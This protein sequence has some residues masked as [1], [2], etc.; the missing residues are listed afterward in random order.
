MKILPSKHHN[1]QFTLNILRVLLFSLLFIFFYFLFILFMRV[2]CSSR[3]RDIRYVMSI[4]GS[5][6]MRVAINRQR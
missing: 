2:I 3:I 1:A 4:S 6:I 5:R